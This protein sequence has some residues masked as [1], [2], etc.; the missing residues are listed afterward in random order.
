[1]GAGREA[2]PNH[3]DTWMHETTSFLELGER[4][5]LIILTPGRMRQRPFCTKARRRGSRSMIRPR[6]QRRRHIE[7]APWKSS[8]PE[9]RCFHKA[10][11]RP[12][13]SPSRRLEPRRAVAPANPD[14]AGLSS[15]TISTIS[16]S[17]MMAARGSERFRWSCMGSEYSPPSIA[18][19]CHRRTHTGCRTGGLPSP[20]SVVRCSACECL[21]PAV[22][23]PNPIGPPYWLSA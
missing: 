11:R 22:P 7:A 2:K 6:T 18:R 16:R 21:T 12:L 8:H 17:A 23:G 19:R 20:A 5:S 10:P 3:L 14:G 1:M 9:T 13:P 15:H 4:L